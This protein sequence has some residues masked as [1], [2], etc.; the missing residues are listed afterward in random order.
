MRA[1]FHGRAVW[2]CV[3]GRFA[4]EF[5]VFRRPF[6]QRRLAM[7]HPI[8][9]LWSVGPG[10]LVLAAGVLSLAGCSAE[11]QPVTAEAPKY[12][13]VDAAS[14]DA[15]SSATTER[16]TTSPGDLTAE[17]TQIRSFSA[18]AGSQ[19]PVASD[20]AAPGFQDS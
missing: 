7:A 9:R 16:P 8:M 13:P 6:M 12:R 17:G 19:T 11:A 4:L 2:G 18:N 3:L 20:P 14:A 5:A 15:G 10:V 1:V